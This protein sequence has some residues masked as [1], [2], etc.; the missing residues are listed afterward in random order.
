VRR[1]FPSASWLGG[2]LGLGV[3]HPLVLLASWT[4]VFKTCL[5][6][7]LTRP[8]SRRTIL[9]GCLR[10]LPWMLFQDTVQR[11]APSM[12]E[13]Q[14]LITKTCSRRKWFQSR[15]S[16][17]AGEPPDR[18]G[19]GDGRGGHLVESFFRDGVVAA[20][21]HGPAGAVRGGVAWIFSSLNVYLRDTAQVLSVIMTFWFWF[22][23][24]FIARATFREA[25]FDSEAESA[26]LPG[27]RL[28]RAAAFEPAPS[29]REMAIIAAYGAVRF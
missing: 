19:A 14:N 4:F 12:V 29:L 10:F 6:I 1:D 20:C 24:I 11:S 22:T 27:E 3:I 23:P 9:C 5:K 21:L 26:G 18:P 7:E 25:A 2:G 16:F 28:S 17:F 8:T 13:H 15:F